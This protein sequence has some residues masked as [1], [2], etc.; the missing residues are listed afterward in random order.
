M[1]NA[2]MKAACRLVMVVS[3]SK[4]E[5]ANLD[6]VGAVAA[7]CGW[8]VAR[9][10]AAVKKAH[11]QFGLLAEG[12][13]PATDAHLAEL[14]LTIAGNEH[15]YL[16][17]RYEHILAALRDWPVDRARRAFANASRCGFLKWIDLS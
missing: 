6:E 15:P 4:E 17:L 1:R 10:A 16:K 11:A 9:A 7:I 12:S 14:L 3:M 5:R 8:T 2:D 13:E